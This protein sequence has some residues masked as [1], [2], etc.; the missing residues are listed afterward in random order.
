MWA[1]SHSSQRIICAKNSQEPLA[2]LGVAV[3][4]SDNIE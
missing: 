2:E 3:T 4:L 1:A